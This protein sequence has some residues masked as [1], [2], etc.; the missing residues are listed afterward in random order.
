MAETFK[1]A[2]VGSGPSGLSAAGRAAALSASYVLLEAERHPADTIFKYQKG[3]F[4]M[5]EPSIL[6]LRS[7]F[8]FAA[9]SRESIL[10]KWDE[11]LAQHK[12]NI[13]YGAGVTAIT[14]QKG[15]FTLK[16]AKGDTVVAENVVLAIG[17]RSGSTD[18]SA[19][20]CLPFWYL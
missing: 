18:G 14:G 12:V 15:A 5:A 10:G 6:P 11:E 9:G 8:S 2:I 7:T 17:L 13:R 20:T 3:K 4:V 16:L 19:I 1:I